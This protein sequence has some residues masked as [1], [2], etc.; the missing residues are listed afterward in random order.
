MHFL[1]YST[2]YI[3]EFYNSSFE[4]EKNSGKKCLTAPLNVRLLCQP[5]AA[6]SACAGRR[7]VS[8]LDHIIEYSYIWP[9][10]S[11]I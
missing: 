2:A 8:L 3:C 10:L 9:D 7:P 11:N 6:I 5:K 1:L 4:E